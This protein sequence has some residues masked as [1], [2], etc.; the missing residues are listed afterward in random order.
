MELLRRYAKIFWSRVKKSAGCWLWQGPPGS[1]YGQFRVAGHNIGPNRFSLALKLRRVPRGFAC[2]TC[3]TPLCVRQKHLYEGTPAS[4]MADRD[5]RGRTAR[6]EKHGANTRLNEAKIRTIRSLY[7]AGALRQV[8]IAKRFG[9]TQSVVSA[10][11][12]RK[13]WKVVP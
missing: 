10:I 13:I 7:A 6:G 9:I 5:V 8:D 2:H 3:D 11:V 1:G 4:N 12:L